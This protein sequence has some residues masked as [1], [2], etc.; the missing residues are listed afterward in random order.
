M[1]EKQKLYAYVDE[2]GQDTR[3]TI[4]LVSVV[5]TG[6]ER[7]AVRERL[8]AIERTSGKRAKKWTKARIKERVAYIQQLIH[9]RGLV[10]PIYYAHYRNTRTYVDLMIFSTAKALHARVMDRP[11][12][13]IIVDGLER[14]ERPRF[15]AGIRKLGITVHKVR[16]ARDQS[17]E[18]IRLAD[19]IAGFVRD[20]LE[21]DP[22]IR[23][24]FERA[25]RQ[26]LIEE[27]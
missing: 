8:R 20:A 17:D 5:V 11:T 23:V 15:A 22:A 27:V 12:A 16:G 13:T 19:A 10:G 25:K 1:A 2:S 7:D 9:A 3:G 4:F 14:S 18:L 26:R 6:E 24:L 21:G